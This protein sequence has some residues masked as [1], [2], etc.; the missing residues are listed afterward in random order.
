MVARIG[1]RVGVAM[2]L[3]L[4]PTLAAY[5]CIFT[6]VLIGP[7]ESNEI[8]SGATA[9]VRAGEVYRIEIAMRENHNNCDLEAD[10]TMFLLEEGRWRVGRETQPLVLR[11]E[12]E[13]ER[14]GSRS[15]TTAIEFL[16]AE[17][18]TWTIDVVRECHRGGCHEWIAIET[19]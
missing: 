11:S 6:Y 17:I 1:R 15:Y 18:G 3:F 9:T 7:D 8:R 10:D 13:W 16:A 5:A 2:A 19:R 14:T 4:L 12:I